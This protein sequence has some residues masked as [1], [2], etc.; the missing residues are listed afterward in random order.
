MM[1]GKNKGKCIKAKYQFFQNTSTPVVSPKL[2][3][4]AAI[5]SY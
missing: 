3:D 4:D 1:Y 5:G 2:I